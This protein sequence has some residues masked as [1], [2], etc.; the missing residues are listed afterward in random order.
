MKEYSTRRRL[1]FKSE[2][3]EVTGV[4]AGRRV[5]RPEAEGDLKPPDF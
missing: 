1:E 2:K 3:N 4:T 5:R